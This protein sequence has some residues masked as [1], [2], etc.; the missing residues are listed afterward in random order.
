V[1]ARFALLAQ[2]ADA[3]RDLHDAGVVRT[4]GAT[5]VLI[6]GVTIA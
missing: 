5:V 4:L 3:M 6:S 2:R 1:F